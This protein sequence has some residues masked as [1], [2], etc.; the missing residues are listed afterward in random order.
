MIIPIKNRSK[1]DPKSE[2]SDVHGKNAQK[3]DN[4]RFKFNK[5]LTEDKIDENEY[6]YLVS[7]V[8]EATPFVSNIAGT[9]GAYLKNW[10]KRSFKKLELNPLNIINNNMK[11]KSYNEELKINSTEV[12]WEN[13]GP[14]F[15]R[16]E[17]AYN[18]ILDTSSNH[19]DVYI[20]ILNAKVYNYTNVLEPSGASYGWEQIENGCSWAAKASFH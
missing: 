18:N 3:I 17:N 16:D 10:D 2:K 13:I 4:L 8:I 12:G 14:L 20:D 7:L 5:W 6:F 15:K 1:I 11:N 19:N 9:Y